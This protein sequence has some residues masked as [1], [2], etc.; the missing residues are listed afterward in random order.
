MKLNRDKYIS[1]FLS[2]AEENIASVE[3]ALMIFKDDPSAIAELDRILRSFHILKGSARMLAF[4]GVEALTHAA[5]SAFISVRDRRVTLDDRST[6]LILLA[7]DELKNALKEIVASKTD[8]TSGAEEIKT[9]LISFA[10]AEDFKLPTHE[11]QAPQAHKTEI[12]AIG[13]GSVRVDTAKI[14]EIIRSI[15]A[16]QS[17]NGEAW[18]IG[19]NAE[20]LVAVYD[21]L[22]EKIKE[23]GVMNEEVTTAAI[24]F[25]RTLRGGISRTKRRF[26]AYDAGLKKAYDAA[27]SL[28]MMPLS[29]ILDN[30]SRLVYD[31]A[32]EIGK[33]A[34]IVIEG[35][36]NEI[37]KT[38]I[39]ALE[40][41]LLHLVRNALDH[42]IEPPDEREKLGKD[43]VGTI[44]IACS[45][46]SG[47]MKISISDDGKGIDYDAVKNRVIK[48]GLRSAE[49]AEKMVRTELGNYIF[50]SGLS[51][52]KEITEISG[53]GV[54]MDAAR[55]AIEHIKGTIILKSEVNKGSIF[56]IITPL[57][58]ASFMGFPV[59]VG[60]HKFIIPVN[61]IDNVLLVE[62]NQIINVIDRPSIEYDGR[63]VRL[64]FLRNVLRIKQA[65]IA[66][67]EAAQFVVIIHAYD[68]IAAF[69]VGGIESM[70]PVIVKPLPRVMSR[71]APF[72]GAILDDNGAIAPV[73]QI[74]ALLKMA[75][76]VKPIDLKARHIEYERTLKR[77]LVVDDSAPIREI[78][79]DI[80]SN[81]GYIVDTADDGAEALTLLKD[82]RYDLVC[83]DINM[84][85]MDGFELAQNIR[86]NFALKDL[87]IVIVSL[88]SSQSDRD[89][90]AKIGVNRYIVKNSFD[91]KSLIG[92]VKELIGR[93]NVG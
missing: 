50:Q 51:T 70:R 69:A 25:G 84:P 45:R 93:P 40:I 72:S 34:R 81:E 24:T 4:K 21:A 55:T 68:E 9:A 46:E 53:R 60:E 56:T 48:M 75:H 92:A 13:E 82:R 42:G 27:L 80:L 83:T 77:I 61:F 36:Q 29:T 78:A 44:K 30:Y 63:V 65:N 16:I 90:S 74:P 33:R 12:G 37:D 57:S 28:R 64:Y 79:K 7:V 67:E 11:Q 86:E 52:K 1:K 19:R 2:E 20:A 6:H 10:N 62:Q 23:S 38:V 14:D 59:T 49:E 85:N 17:S 39:D 43:P 15:A 91:N 88:R 31:M 87:P 3:N 66:D 58:I 5:E 35:A 89:R 41:A 22:Y 76:R 47:N 71:F 18:E 26:M 54:G 8:Q 32:G 73:L